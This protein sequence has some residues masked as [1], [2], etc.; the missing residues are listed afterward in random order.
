M[1]DNKENIKRNLKGRLPGVESVKKDIGDV[2]RYEICLHFNLSYCLIKL[3]I[4]T[5]SMCVIV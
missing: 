1:E 3:H 2:L 5:S 4:D